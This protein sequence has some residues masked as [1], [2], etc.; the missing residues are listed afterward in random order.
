MNSDNTKII[1]GPPGTG[2]TTYLMSELD[3]MF[4]SFHPTKICFV[5]F[6]KKASNEAMERAMERFDLYEDDLILFRTM[7]SLA[8]D[9]LMLGRNNIMSTNDYLKVAKEAGVGISFQMFDD[10]GAPI[11]FHKGNVLLNIINMAKCTKKSIKAVWELFDEAVFYEEVVE[12]KEV[13]DTY[14]MMNSKKDFNDMIIDFSNGGRKPEMQVLFI[15]EAQDL[16]AIQ[17]DM[18]NYLSRGTIHNYIAGDDDQSIFEWAGADVDQF[19]N[20]KGEV[21]ILNQSWRVPSSIK[22]ISA[23]IVQRIKNRREK[24]WKSKADEGFVDYLS[25][26]NELTDMI[27]EGEWLLLA[28]T[29]SMLKDYEEICRYAG[30]FYR[31]AHVNKDFSLIIRAIRNWIALQEGKVVLARRVKE[32]YDLMSSVERIKHGSKSDLNRLDDKEAL[33]IDMLKDKF[34]LLCSS[35]SWDEALDKLN[36]SDKE[37]VRSAI[38]TDNIDQPRITI[39]TIHGAKGGESDNVVIKSDMG[40]RAFSAMLDN[41]D[42][43][44][45]VWYVGVTRAKQNLYIINPETQ[46][47]YDV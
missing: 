17:W 21:K 40:L 13:L 3:K 29:N 46:Y 47:S 37:Y 15:D 41:P 24:E 31:Y 27:K 11:G 36:P 25:S 43:E 5:S 20:L 7:H 45:R 19:I 10:F 23:K 2:K 33:K 8:F 9:S 18:A 22:N 6:T 12:F 14:K 35:L 4:R 30:V 16:S 42:A 34:G 32:I 26:A 38:Q 1:L 44:H 39:S 28:R